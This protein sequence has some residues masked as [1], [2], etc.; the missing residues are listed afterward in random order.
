MASHSL[1]SI[2]QQNKSYD[3][4]QKSA[5]QKGLRVWLRHVKASF[6]FG[7]FYPG[8]IQ[9]PSTLK[10]DY[11]HSVRH[12]RASPVREKKS[13]TDQSLLKITT[14]VPVVHSSPGPAR[15][16]RAVFAPVVQAGFFPVVRVKGLN[17]LSKF[18]PLTFMGVQEKA[19]SLSVDVMAFKAFLQNNLLDDQVEGFEDFG[20]F[21]RSPTH[22]TYALVVMFRGLS[23]K[24][25]QPL[26]YYLSNGPVMDPHA[27]TS[28]V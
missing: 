24:W 11:V 5:S 10:L 13:C 22:A 1:N 9:Y 28:A 17:S 21:G 6:L 12:G 7:Q 8:G 16:F 19:C 20:Q 27:C 23:T 3:P 26:F 25:N 4:C 14:T 18:S 2:P 15:V